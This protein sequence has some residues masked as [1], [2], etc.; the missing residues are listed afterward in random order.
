MK[1][2]ILFLFASMPFFLF[3]QQNKIIS[4][5]P[6]NTI[7]PFTTAHKFIQSEAGFQLST[8]KLNIIKRDRLLN[9][10][11]LVTKYGIVKNV[12]L[13]LITEFSSL[14]ESNINRDVYYRGIS[15][16]QLGTKLFL[17]KQKY[18]RPNIGLV[19]HYNFNTLRKTGF[20]KDTINGFN[21]RLLFEHIIKEKFS[22]AY[23][24]G[25]NIQTFGAKEAYVYSFSPRYNFDEKFS[26]YIELFGYAWKKRKPNNSLHT[27][28]SYF[29]NDNFKVDASIGLGFSKLYTDRFYSIGAS[30]R[31]NTK[32]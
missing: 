3:A 32:N 9:I 7:L 18:L 5:R 2:S 21:F 4:D 1:I 12:E 17:V 11:T 29:I 15:N 8:K 26:M 27:G 28:V 13:R 16:F 6:S 20:G 10:P 25:M 24:L 19:A 30:Y 14:Y 23:N 22:V 31:F